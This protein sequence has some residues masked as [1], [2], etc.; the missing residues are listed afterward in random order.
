MTGLTLQMMVSEYERIFVEYI[1]LI[2]QVGEG[3]GSGPDGIRTI[4]DIKAST[5]T[6]GATVTAAIT[7]ANDCW[8]QCTGDC[9]ISAY[10]DNNTCSLYNAPT[11]SSNI[12]YAGDSTATSMMTNETYLK[13]N[14]LQF[15]SVLQKY[16]TNIQK[17]IAAQDYTPQQLMGINILAST[18]MS[19]KAILDKD[20]D[21]VVT[22]LGKLEATEETY[23]NTYM[24]TTSNHQMLNIWIV[25]AI[26]SVLL[27]FFLCYNALK[28]R[29]E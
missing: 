13:Y 11:G 17:Y 25:V 18:L 15:N 4:T 16:I 23:N 19:H 2:N 3:S 24:Q 7:N 1:L 22:Q 5:N 27:A 14:I 9:I 20:R 8:T 12:A 26:V 10:K 21:W 6:P 28:N 29:E